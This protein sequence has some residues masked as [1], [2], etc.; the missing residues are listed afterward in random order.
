[1]N[2]I[3]VILITISA[4]MLA[5]SLILVT[6]SKSVSIK[7]K[8]IFKNTKNVRKI[9]LIEMILALIILFIISIKW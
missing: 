9:G 7:I 2:T 8:Q 1:M 3:Q 4:L 6:F 5:E